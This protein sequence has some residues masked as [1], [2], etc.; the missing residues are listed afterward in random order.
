MLMH[1]LGHLL[2]SSVNRLKALS[3]HGLGYVWIL[4]FGNAFLL[5]CILKNAFSKMSF[6]E[7]NV[8]SKILKLFIKSDYV[9]KNC[10]CLV[11]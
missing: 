4:Y 6:T 11:F 2:A 3:Q 7:N 5:E 10:V 1:N 9:K 8:F